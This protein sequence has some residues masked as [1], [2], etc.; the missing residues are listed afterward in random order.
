MLNLNPR[1]ISLVQELIQL[2]SSD[3]R[4]KIESRRSS[5]N[6]QCSILLVALTIL[7]TPSA[8]D[9]LLPRAFLENLL[10]YKI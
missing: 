5:Q 8:Q 1:Q 10:F 3:I 2:Y 6:K 4:Q 9:E 7:D